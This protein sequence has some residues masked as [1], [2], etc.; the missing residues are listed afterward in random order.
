MR[1]YFTFQMQLGQLFLQLYAFF[2]RKCNI[3]QVAL[4]DFYSE[5]SFMLNGQWLPKTQASF[6]L[7][8]SCCISLCPPGSSAW[9]QSWFLFHE[10]AA[11]CT[12]DRMPWSRSGCYC[13]TNSG[14]NAHRKQLCVY[15]NCLCLC[16]P[17]YWDAL[18]LQ[19]VLAFRRDI[20]TFPLTQLSLVRAVNSR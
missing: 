9:G 7:C 6:S 3:L 2:D 1:H 12:A 18:L 11:A 14:N 17:S 5:L 20:S 13:S 16:S 19:T 10:M 8:F 4:Q 15:A